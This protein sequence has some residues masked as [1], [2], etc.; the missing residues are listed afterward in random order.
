[1]SKKQSTL[2][3]GQKRK[4]ED[5]SSAEESNGD[6]DKSADY[7][8]TKPRKKTKKATSKQS[9]K[10]S[11]KPKSKIGTLAMMPLFATPVEKTK[12]EPIV[13]S[14]SR[15]VEGTVSTEL[16]NID[17][18]IYVSKIAPVFRKPDEVKRVNAMKKRQGFLE[19][20]QK[21]RETDKLISKNAS[22]NPLMTEQSKQIRKEQEKKE[23]ELKLN[24]GIELT[25][26][27]PEDMFIDW[28][29]VKPLEN[30]PTA[31]VWSDVLPRLEVNNS[32]IVDDLEVIA[33]EEIEEQPIEFTLRRRRRPNQSVAE[34][35]PITTTLDMNV[36]LEEHFF[37]PM[38][39]PKN[40]ELAIKTA[41]R[42]ALYRN[43]AADREAQWSTLYKPTSQQELVTSHGANINH[44][45]S[46]INT[47]PVVDEDEMNGVSTKLILLSGAVGCGKTA[48][49]HAIA[50][51]MG[52]QVLEVHPFDDRTNIIKDLSEATQSGLVK[53]QKK[54]KIVL[55]D[56][57][58]VTAPLNEDEYRSFLASVKKLLTISKVPIVATCNT[59]NRELLKVF[60][61][62]NMVLLEMSEQYHN[63]NLMDRIS[64]LFT[65][66]LSNHVVPYLY[67][68]KTLLQVNGIDVRKS[69]L[70]MQWRSH[71]ATLPELSTQQEVYTTHYLGIDRICIELLKRRKAFENVDDALADELEQ[72][73]CMDIMYHNYTTSSEMSLDDALEYITNMATLDA[74]SGK[75]TDQ[76][77]NDL[78]ASHEVLN[79]RQYASEQDQCTNSMN[80]TTLMLINGLKIT[81][82]RGVD[83]GVTREQDLKRVVSKERH[84]RFLSND[85]DMIQY[86]ACICKME[87]Q[88]KQVENKRRF[89]YSMRDELEAFEIEWLAKFM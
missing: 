41:N 39:I 66:A 61:I 48:V 33:E 29:S 85:T 52:Y 24:G 2:N 36:A 54:N 65:V 1:M 77:M 71:K 81:N 51:E 67:D 60:N 9:P 45:V 26:E 88:R 84:D 37:K 75:Y 12:I 87:Y 73:R 86:Q 69:L 15:V 42:L 20:I 31:E 8:P 56:E 13:P 62:S 23:K 63:V 80:K 35:K 25:K 3:F 58:D 89:V 57:I 19:Q 76:E 70:T 64:L 49:V 55:F 34:H 10:K 72:G 14:I 32:I 74:T 4:R 17:S 11:T 27:R 21:D 40:S 38:N 44:L 28:S 50:E 47:K 5:S 68:L 18:D 6:D 78:R 46:S 79:W 43:R 82:T 59:V 16:K 30:I 83:A 7:N 22:V 53:K